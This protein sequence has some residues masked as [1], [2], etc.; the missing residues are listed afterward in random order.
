MWLSVGSAV[1]LGL[2]IGLLLPNPDETG[3][4][5]ESA[6]TGRAMREPGG[7]TRPA[8]HDPSVAPAYPRSIQLPGGPSHEFPLSAADVR[9]T[10]EAPS[11][12]VDQAGRIFLAWAS[13]TSDL[14]RTLY[15][16]TSSDEGQSYEQPRAIAVSGIF[17]SAGADPDKRGGHER[18]MSP[19]LAIS[20]EGLLLAWCDAPRDGSRVS[21]LLVES[22]DGGGSFSNPSP[23]HHSDAARP[24]F[25]SLAVNLAGRCAASWLDSR[26]GVQQVFAAARVCGSPSFEDELLVY[27]GQDNQGVCPCC[28][29]ATYVASDG[30]VVVAWRNEIDGYRDVWFSL[31]DPGASARFTAPVPVVPPTWKFDGCPHDGPSLAMSHE[32]LHVAWMDAH[33]GRPRVY[34]ARAGRRDLKFV[35]RELNA[36]GPGTQGNPKL[37]FDGAGRLHA[38]WEESLADEPL[39][40][41][42]GPTHG[43]SSHSPGASGA[44]RVIMHACSPHADGLFG[45]A[46][47]ILSRPGRF[48][49][50][51]AI[52]AGPGE[53]LVAAWNELDE[54]GKRVIVMRLGEPFAGP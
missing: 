22:R 49:T 1:I 31:L 7:A 42:A 11:V 51:P 47:P 16:T 28:P 34:Y 10:Q 13:K 25:T 15:F 12:A 41:P 23:I 4:G 20:G 52:A 26:H 17:K 45:S 50:R 5:A 24:T 53:L 14:E 36:A 18:R 54:G 30:T 19:R 37:C 44:G 21:M 38:L 9:D 40:A 29:T 46:R 27:A 43:I 2:A 3:E 48:Q 33:S 8:Q 6:R 32:W 39:A 35:V